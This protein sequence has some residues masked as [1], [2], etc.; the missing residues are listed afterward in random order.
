MPLVP[1]RPDASATA[2]ADALRQAFP[3]DEVTLEED[4]F[5]SA[6]S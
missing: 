4:A 5:V 3:G 6:R 2:L 1:E